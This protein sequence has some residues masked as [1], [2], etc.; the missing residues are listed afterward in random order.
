MERST[1]EGT[2]A[3]RPQVRKLVLVLDDDPSI[4]DSISDIVTGELNWDVAVF[5]EPHAALSFLRPHLPDLLVL[6][7]LMPAIDGLQFYDRVRAGSDTGAIAV[8]FVSAVRD[9]SSLEE[10]GVPS[11]IAFV[12]KPF[13][14][15]TFL[16]A[17]ETLVGK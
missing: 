16:S 8:L 1:Q 3:E 5:T 6:D 4:A 17:V 13:D 10:L 15:D 7:V 12:S 14:V 2:V 11:K 9:M